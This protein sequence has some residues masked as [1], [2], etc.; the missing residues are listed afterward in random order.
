MPVK[1]VFGIT[2]HSA[3]DDAGTMLQKG[4]VLSSSC[5]RVL[6]VTKSCGAL[7]VR[8]VVRLLKVVPMQQLARGRIEYYLI[9][10]MK[11]RRSTNER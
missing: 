5:W 9:S 1:Q 8:V 6:M 7:G 3:E 2:G 10:H 11:Y 4:R